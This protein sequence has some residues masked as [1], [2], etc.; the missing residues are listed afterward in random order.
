M[1][2]AGLA[3]ALYTSDRRRSITLSGVHNAYASLVEEDAE[4]PPDLDTS[5]D[6]AMSTPDSDPLPLKT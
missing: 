1:V 2:R 5:C 3:T 4:A 6:W